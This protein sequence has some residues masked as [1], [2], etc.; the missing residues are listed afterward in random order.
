MNRDVFEWAL[1]IDLTD[2]LLPED[3]ADIEQSADRPSDQI[4]VRLESVA[5]WLFRSATVIDAG[6]KKID[7]EIDLFNESV[8]RY[9][10]LV[11]NLLFLYGAVVIFLHLL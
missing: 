1:S 4:R 2:E 3:Q 9:Q 5:A 11:V 7:Q 10:M 8:G 6:V